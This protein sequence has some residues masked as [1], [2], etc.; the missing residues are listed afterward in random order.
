MTRKRP[1]VLGVD[2]NPSEL[3]R[4]L[5]PFARRDCVLLERAAYP[6]HRARINSKLFGNDVDTRPPGAMPAQC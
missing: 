4:P 6:L 3:T 1:P 5:L 2:L